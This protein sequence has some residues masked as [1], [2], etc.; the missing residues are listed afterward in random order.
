MI[1]MKRAIASIGFIAFAVAACSD[2]TTGPDGGAR[3]DS[4]GVDVFANWAYVSLFDGTPRLVSVADA[5]NSSAWDIGFFATAVT[6]N[7]GAAGPAGVLGYCVCQNGALSDAQV[8]ALRASDGLSAFEAVGVSAIP[9]A[10]SLWRSDALAPAIAGWWRYNSTTR[11][12]SAVPDTSYLVRAS[13]GQSFAKFRVVQIANATQSTAGRVTFEYALQAAKGAA[14]GAVQ[15]ASIDVPATSRVHFDLNSGTQIETGWDLAFQ[16]YNIQVNGG[17]SG[18]GSAG[19]IASGTPFGN[20]T[21][22]SAP[23]A[24]VYRADAFG[25]VFQGRKW[26]R[27]NITGADNQI[28]PTY[29]VYLI[30]RG[31][32]VYKVQLINYYNAS[33][34]ERFITFRYAKLTD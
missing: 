31:S 30:K 27:Y 16:G 13:D 19:A 32:A 28:W 11:E 22:A 3:P 12:V 9:T 17:V 23:P 1:L 29:D 25:G 14:M 24:S 15:S 20:I 21:D 8:G 18:N 10:D 2:E 5:A 4:L 26:Y 34:R 6:V 7:G 33:G